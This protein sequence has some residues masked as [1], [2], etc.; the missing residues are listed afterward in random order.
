[1]KDSSPFYNVYMANKKNI[2]KAIKIA[3]KEAARKM[4]RN[5]HKVFSLRDK[6]LV[7]GQ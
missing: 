4:G 7:L 2:D 1:M 6:S 5:F 3:T